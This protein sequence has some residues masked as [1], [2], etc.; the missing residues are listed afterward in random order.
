VSVYDFS[1]RELI[2]IYKR[3]IRTAYSIMGRPV[4]GAP[5]PKSRERE[6][7]L[8][9]YKAKKTDDY[10]YRELAIIPFFAGMKARIVE[11]YR[12]RIKY[13]F[14]DY[15]AVAK[16]GDKEYEEMLA[17]PQMFRNKL[18]IKAAMKNAC[19]FRDVVEQSGSFLEYIFDFKPHKSYENL[20]TL[21]D[22]FCQR[23]AAYGPT[24]T[25]HFFMSIG[26]GLPL[27]KPDLNMMR[28]F[29]R[30]GLVDEDGNEDATYCAAIRM[31]EAA[32][33]NVTS[34][35]SF[36]ELGLKDF[37]Y[38]SSEVCGLEPDCNRK[39]NPCQIQEL[40]GEWRRRYQ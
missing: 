40:C 35:D 2:E 4:E 3:G 15:R 26:I 23:F 19:E 37:Y 38:P 20:F 13:W 25:K 6:H 31:A 5:D 18:K 30:I 32:G 33:V 28:T 10:L 16:Y 17:D 11:M 8:E 29:Y 7:T 24:T 22:D 36:V 12:G 34:V 9:Y 21:L 39:K 27:I 1:E 14:H